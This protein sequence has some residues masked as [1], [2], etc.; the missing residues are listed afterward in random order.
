MQLSEPAAQIGLPLDYRAEKRTGVVEAVNNE[1]LV[2]LEWHSITE[3]RA[4]SDRLKR[5]LHILVINHSIT[6][7]RSLSDR[8]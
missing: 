1:N 6:E 5:R 3:P 4:L 8:V 2:I 7:P